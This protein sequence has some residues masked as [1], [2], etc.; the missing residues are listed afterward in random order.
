MSS[1]TAPPEETADA[2]Y[3]LLRPYRAEWKRR[4]RLTKFLDQ[5]VRA[6][7]KDD[8][9]QLAELLS[10]KAAR[11]ARAEPGLGDAG[12]L[13]DQLKAHAEEQINDYR[14]QFVS[15]LGELAAAAGLGLT[16]DFPRLK[17]RP[18][19]AGLIDFDERKVK[20]NDKTVKSVDPKKIVTALAR[21]D[22]RLHGRAFD[23]QAFIDGLYATWRILNTRAGGGDQPVP[24][25]RFYREHVLGRQSS[26]FFGDM[27]KRRFKGYPLDEFSVDLWR[28]YSSDV[29]AT[30]GGWRLAL[31]PGRGQSLS[32]LDAAGEARNIT[33]I[34]FQQVT[35]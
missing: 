33:S 32:L 6:A 1:Q 23:A 34:S 28:F 35:S 17:G 12:A 22:K 8:F 2:L 7:R 11:D 16:I 9:F 31:R 29:R 24:I 21:L 3:D 4:E 5:C 13:L 25:R 20:I 19:I 30:S 26:R 18:G 14:L 27:D 15:E 10:K